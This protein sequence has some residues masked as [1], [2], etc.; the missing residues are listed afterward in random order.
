MPGQWDRSLEIM[1]RQMLTETQPAAAAFVGG[2]QGIPDEYALFSEIRP[3]QPRFAVGRPGGAARAI[4]QDQ[5]SSPLRD[6]LLTGSVY[7]SIWHAVLQDLD[8]VA[9]TDQDRDHP[10]DA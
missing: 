10:L 7:P 2:M 9:T 1:R 3:G 5:P 6:Q 4:A 8:V